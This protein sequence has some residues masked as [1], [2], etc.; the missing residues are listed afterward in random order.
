[1]LPSS[2]SAHAVVHIRD[3]VRSLISLSCLQQK[4]F[5]AQ[6]ELEPSFTADGALLGDVAD[7]TACLR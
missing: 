1:M 3:R 5:T 7:S 4:A 2:L 6:T